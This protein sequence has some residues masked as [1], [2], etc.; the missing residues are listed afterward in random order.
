MAEKRK[1]LRVLGRK[2]PMLGNPTQ[3]MLEEIRDTMQR[4]AT[5][6]TTIERMAAEQAEKDRRK[7]N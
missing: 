5:G 3:R 7:I 4:L 6:E 1:F 2:H